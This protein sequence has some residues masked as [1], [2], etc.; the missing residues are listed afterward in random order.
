MRLE[1]VLLDCVALISRTSSSSGSL[2]G[3]CY[4][5]KDS[6]MVSWKIKISF[7][8]WNQLQSWPRSLLRI[9]KISCRRQSHLK[10]VQHLNFGSNLSMRWIKTI[11]ESVFQQN[12]NVMPAVNPNAELTDPNT[13]PVVVERRI[14]DVTLVW[15][16]TEM[17]A[18]SGNIFLTL[19][20]IKQECGCGWPSR[21]LSFRRK[22]LEDWIKRTIGCQWREVIIEI[23]WIVW[24]SFK[25]WCIVNKIVT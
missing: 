5:R 18:S 13:S 9:T 22:V 2:N 4:P 23:K 6:P 16:T 7:Q 20:P 14:N 1:N 12:N 21:I 24:R 15:R 19:D 11:S 10:R 3:A 8:L 25:V 17:K